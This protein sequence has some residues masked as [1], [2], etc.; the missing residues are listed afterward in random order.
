[1]NYKVEFLKNIVL[2]NGLKDEDIDLIAENSSVKKF[3]KKSLIFL[4]KEEGRFFYI[5]TKGRLKITQIDSEG[6][7]VI[8]S[9][10]VAGEYFGEMA[11]ID[12][13][14]RCANAQ[15]ME[16]VELLAI[17][18]TDFLNMLKS[19]P[20]L[21]YNLLKTFAVRLREADS[22]V[23]G[24]FLDNAKKRI[25]NTL[26]NLA[27][28]M[29]EMEDG[30]MILSSI[31]QTDLANISGTSR[32]TLSRILKKLDDEKV[33]RKKEKSIILLRYKELKR[34]LDND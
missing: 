4:E 3:K 19:V 7:E 27:E 34:K 10:L 2:C 31:N 29:G 8:L 14:E 12:D 9:M 20:G 5:I 26:I 15:A 22:Y 16:D 11:I 6:N 33:I 28:K 23:K 1:M 13:V 24:L 30:A 32:E 17:S 21:S 18:D 25:L